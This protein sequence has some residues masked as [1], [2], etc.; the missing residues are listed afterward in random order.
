MDT[1]VQKFAGKIKGVLSGFDRIVFKGC[2]RP[3]MFA[4]GAMS[5]FRSRGVLN[6]DYKDWVMAQSNAIV[7]QMATLRDDKPMRE[8][9]REITRP[10]TQNGRRIRALDVTGKGRE[11]LQ[12]LAD[13]LDAVAG[14]TNKHLRQKLHASPWAKGGTDKQL[15]AR[16]SRHLRLLRDHGLIRKTP[17]HALILPHFLMFFKHF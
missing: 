11:F 15:S 10:S 6:K 9:L 1:F 16:I 17:L 2:L 3:L 13:P 14:I 12:A 8:V 4:D 5:F 7:E